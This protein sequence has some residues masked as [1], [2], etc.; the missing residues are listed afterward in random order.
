MKNTT[1]FILMLQLVF[2]LFFLGGWAQC[3]YKFCNCDFKESYKAEIIYG[4]GIVTG[5]GGVIGWFNFG[6]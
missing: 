1:R 2:I 5:L 6:K 3:I 4:T